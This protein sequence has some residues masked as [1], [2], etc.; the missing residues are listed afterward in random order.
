MLKKS[1]IF[2]S[3]ALVLIAL[4][5]LTGCSQAT[6][7]DKTVRRG[8]NY[9]Y[10]NPSQETAQKAI[11]RAPATGRDVVLVD[12]IKFTGNGLIDFKEATVQVEGRVDVGDIGSQDRLILNASKATFVYAPGAAIEVNRGYFIYR[13]TGVE[14]NAHQTSGGYRVQYTTDPLITMGTADQ[15]AVDS[16][17]IGDKTDFID[18]KTEVHTLIVLDT[19]TV[20]K[21]S[22]DPTKGGKRFVGLKTVDVTGSNTAAFANR[23]VVFYE[24]STLISSNTDPVTIT[25]PSGGVDELG[26][27]QVDNQITLTNTVPDSASGA[28]F[29]VL[30][31]VEGPGTLVIRPAATVTNALTVNLPEV[32]AGGAVTIDNGAI[33]TGPTIT[34]GRNSGEVDIVATQTSAAGV[35]VTTNT[36]AI[37]FT[38]PITTSLVLAVEANNGAITFGEDVTLAGGF[39]GIKAGTGKVVFSGSLNTG[40]NAVTIGTDVVFDGG[41]TRS[42]AGIHTY[43]GNVTLG[44]NQTLDF[45]ATATAINL[46]PGKTIYVAD[47][48]VL[49][50][51]SETAPLTLTPVAGGFKLTTPTVNTETPEELIPVYRKTLEMARAGSAV[52]GIASIT[53]T[54]RVLGNL[55]LTAS[56]DSNDKV[57]ITTSTGKL[58]L[59]PGAL[60]QVVGM[61]ATGNGSTVTFGTGIT[62]GLGTT[63][64]DEEGTGTFRAVDGAVIFGESAITGSSPAAKLLLAD[65]EEAVEPG[66]EGVIN[67]TGSSILKLSSVDLVFDDAG[68][69]GGLLRLANGT[70]LTLDSNNGKPG[71]ITFTTGTGVVLTSTARGAITG[72]ATVVDSKAIPTGSDAVIITD[73][74]AGGT[75]Y[76]ISAGPLFSS[77]IVGGASSAIDL[78]AG[79][80]LTATSL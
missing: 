78:A 40:A 16:Y 27:I 9:I 38:K 71:K 52:G 30:G 18:I 25:F 67:V 35:T 1:L 17:T 6:G 80:S 46:A 79:V 39:E 42:G 15:I 45:G 72:I 21:D 55:V 54:L 53:G 47:V 77:T 31:V 7:S 36:G 37:N 32:A 33:A 44:Y 74:E 69:T 28:A 50:A 51:G 41:L 66:D 70:T 75:L 26:N 34:I 76:S 14:I 4:I 57:D 22:V 3:A 20:T 5:A 10:D 29:S 61:A 56:S 58:A 48:P 63:T 64:A 19:L 23:G 24:G 13:G 12:G 59:E 11:D 8:E 49:A 73:G 43:K 68:V 60:L 65:L 2:G 62:L